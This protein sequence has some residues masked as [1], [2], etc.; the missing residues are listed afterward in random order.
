M[1]A[2]AKYLAQ[3]LTIHRGLRL[4]N[5]TQQTDH[6]QLTF[7]DLSSQTAKAVILAVPCPQAIALL[8]NL[9]SSDT[10]QTLAQITYEPAFS[11]MLVYGQP[12]ACEFPWQELQLTHH[13]IFQTISFD[14]QKR[15]PQAQT[16]VVQ[17]N[18]NFSREYLE[19]DDPDAI[20]KRLIAEIATILSLPLPEVSQLHRWRYA[21]SDKILGATHLNIPTT[22]PLIACGDWC[23]GNGIEGAIAS[24][25]GAS[26]AL[27][28]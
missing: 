9:C 14:G 25:L 27:L 6:W 23:L 18:A 26:Q 24:G 4:E 21:F 11:L 22:L 7:D 1:T 20:T 8:Q 5:L 17:T 12:L 19:T 16:L 15:S 10:T 2:I 28:S 3:A 13:P